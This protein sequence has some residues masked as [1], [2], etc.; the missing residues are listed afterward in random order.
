MRGF[1]KIIFPGGGP[2][3]RFNQLFLRL[4]L[5][6][7]PGRVRRNDFDAWLEFYKQSHYNITLWP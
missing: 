5:T 4:E 6:A 2:K 1:G 3:K 7:A